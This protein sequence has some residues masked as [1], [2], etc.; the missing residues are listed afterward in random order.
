MK[1]IIELQ[2]FKNMKLIGVDP[3]TRR[4]CVER[5]K[6]KIPNARF[7]PAVKLG[8]WDGTVSL[9]SIGGNTYINLLPD[10]YEI[11]TE[12]GYDD[13]T[14]RDNRIGETF[15]HEKINNSLFVD[16]RWEGGKFD[17][18][19]V[20]MMDHQVN[21]VNALTDHD[22]ATIVA[23]TSS[24]KTLICAALCKLTEEHGRT[25]TIVPNRDLVDQ[26]YETYK[27]VGLDAGR[28]YGGLHKITHQ[29]TIT[30]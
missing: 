30:T 16:Y 22:S 25:I 24:G 29:H 28:I 26:T 17:G 6:F 5:L 1:C 18:E 15:L 2:D 20:I 4:K 7:I 3:T 13:I 19:P 14:I 10:V 8:R 11:L 9:C 12:N 23:S 27:L 21:A